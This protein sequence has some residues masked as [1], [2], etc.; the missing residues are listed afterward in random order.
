MGREVA[1]VR[2]VV[3]QVLFVQEDKMLVGLEPRNRGE[4]GFILAV[5]VS[6]RDG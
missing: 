4:M 1:N 5:L 6:D 2:R 3:D